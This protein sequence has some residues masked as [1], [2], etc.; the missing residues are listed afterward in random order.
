MKNKIGILLYKLIE[1]VDGEY[2]LKLI[3]YNIAEKIKVWLLTHWIG[4]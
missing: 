3:P 2:G 4:E 1:H